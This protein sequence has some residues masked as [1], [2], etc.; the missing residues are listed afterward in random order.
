M[1]AELLPTWNSPL[2]S[3]ETRSQ[4]R[5]ER[6]Q[7]VPLDSIFHLHQAALAAEKVFSEHSKC[8]VWAVVLRIALSWLLLPR[9]ELAVRSM[10]RCLEF[11]KLHIE[12]R[13]H[14]SPTKAD[15][16]QWVFLAEVESLGTLSS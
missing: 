15:L 9:S 4:D 8:L 10:C 5:A 11:R 13:S 6:I 12:L 7:A 16:R 2:R 1:L 3:P 14:S